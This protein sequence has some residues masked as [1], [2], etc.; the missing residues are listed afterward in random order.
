M[1][2]G[3]GIRTFVYCLHIKFL[4]IILLTAERYSQFQFLCEWI[5]FHDQKLHF[6]D[7]NQCSNS[8]LK[9]FVRFSF[10]YILSSTLFT[11]GIQYIKDP[12][13]CNTITRSFI[14][15]Y[16]FFILV[17][18]PE[19]IYNLTMQLFLRFLSHFY[20]TFLFSIY[21]L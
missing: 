21:L 19:Q 7:L 11:F 8:I 10:V 9:I 5:F 16:N 6:L 1:C 2:L 14:A 20:I 13:T 18:L 15:H 17:F 4:W 12:F 3:K